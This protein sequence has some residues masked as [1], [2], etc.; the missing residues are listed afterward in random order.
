MLPRGVDDL[1]RM[2]LTDW[3]H[4]RPPCCCC[5]ISSPRQT[6]GTTPRRFDRRHSRAASGDHGLFQ[7]VPAAW[8]CNCA[9]CFYWRGVIPKE[10][11]EADRCG[12]GCAAPSCS[13][14]WRTL[15]STHCTRGATRGERRGGRLR[16]LRRRKICSKRR[17][18]ETCVQCSVYSMAGRA[19]TRASHA[20]EVLYGG[21]RACG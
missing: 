15:C 17:R 11:D 2:T 3:A 8:V 20:T 12:A 5:L 13:R 9:D 7:R 10:G 6:G 1:L 16:R 21:E 18:P 14:V 19:P 4:S